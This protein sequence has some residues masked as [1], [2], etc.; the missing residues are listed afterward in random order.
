MDSLNCIGKNW[1]G[2]DSCYQKYLLTEIYWIIRV[3]GLSPTRLQIIEEQHHGE[4]KQT[5][6][7]RKGIWKTEDRTR[8]AQN[9]W[10]SILPKNTIFFFTKFSESIFI[11][12]QATIKACADD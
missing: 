7:L 2:T 4:M 12:V 9:V 10:Q 1:K 3:A 6:L 8:V 11:Q 5:Q